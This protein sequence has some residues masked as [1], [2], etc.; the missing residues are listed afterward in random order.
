MS[1]LER[2]SS[3]YAR[4]SERKG[5][6]AGLEALLSGCLSD[7]VQGYFKAHKLVDAGFTSQTALKQVQAV[8]NQWQQ[9]SGRCL[10]DISRILACSVGDNRI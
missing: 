8:F 10:A 3:I 1:Q 7:D 9:E 2:F 4:A 5:G 6:P